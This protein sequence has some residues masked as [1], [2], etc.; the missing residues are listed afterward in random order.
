VTVTLTCPRCEAVIEADNEDDLVAKVQ[1][2][3]REDHS[4]EHTLPRKHILSRLRRLEA[5]EDG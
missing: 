4:L 5:A 3:A 2:H 1:T